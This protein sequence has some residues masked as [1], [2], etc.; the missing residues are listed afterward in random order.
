MSRLV[1]IARLREKIQV[2]RLDV[3][4]RSWQGLCVFALHQPGQMMRRHMI[5]AMACFSRF[6]HVTVFNMQLTS[7]TTCKAGFLVK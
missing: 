5:V 6:P 1:A 2:T 7:N 4:H 3:V